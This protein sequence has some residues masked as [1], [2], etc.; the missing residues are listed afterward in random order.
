MCVLVCWGCRY[1]SW[2][3]C[4]SQRT[5][6]RSWVS[7]SSMWVLP[8]ELRSLGLKTSVFI[9]L[10]H[11]ASLSFLLPLLLPLPL[12]L[13]PLFLLI[14]FSYLINFSASIQRNEFHQGIW[15]IYVIVCLPV[16][17]V[18][19]MLPH[20]PSSVLLF[21]S[22]SSSA[23]VYILSAFPSPVSTGLYL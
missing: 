20:S 15:H 18:P 5:D 13:H 14:L 22:P 21:L 1:I 10:R 17:P 4:R 9:H 23:R 3:V 19:Y 12:R 16:S 2:C 8:T 7:S 6:C 11:L